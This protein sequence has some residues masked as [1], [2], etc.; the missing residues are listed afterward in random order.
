MKSSP[1]AWGNTVDLLPVQADAV[2]VGPQKNL[3]RFHP[4]AYR[5]FNKG[6]GDAGAFVT[7]TYVGGTLAH[8]HNVPGGLAAKQGIDWH[9]FTIDLKEGM[10][11]I[12]VV[13]DANKQVAETDE[14]NSY[15]IRVNVKI[16]CDG[17]DRKSDVSGKRVSVRVEL[18]GRRI[19]K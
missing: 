2:Q 4:A 5:S 6:D 10:N 15:Q 14:N 18:G 16:A 8:T 3:C 11:V 19:S 12:R 7:K 1:V 13:F 9:Q 17:E